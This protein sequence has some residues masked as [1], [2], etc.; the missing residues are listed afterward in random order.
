MRPS[1]TARPGGRSWRRSDPPIS[2]Q[3]VYKR[4]RSVGRPLLCYPPC[5]PRIPA[6]SRA[7]IF[8]VGRHS[9]ITAISVRGPSCDT[10]SPCRCPRIVRE[11]SPGPTSRRDPSSSVI[12]PPPGEDDVYLLVRLMSVEPDARPRFKG[13]PAHHFEAA[14]RRPLAARY[15]GK[16]PRLSGSSLD[17]AP[18]RRFLFGR[19]EQHGISHPLHFLCPALP[20][21]NKKRRRA[22]PLSPTP[23]TKIIPSLQFL[24]NGAGTPRI[25]VEIP[26]GVWR[27][28]W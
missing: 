14:L 25:C 7:G 19:L 5:V 1:R 24:S 9:A 16:A 21:K 8:P 3:P 22:G 20:S 23:P 2:R 13:H 18:Y 17:L 11:T 26:E 6:S 15:R 12:D 27:P 10:S 28:L 4:G